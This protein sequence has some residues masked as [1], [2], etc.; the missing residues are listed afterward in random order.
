MVFHLPTV[1]ILQTSRYYVDVVL[2]NVLM[3]IPYC[4]DTVAKQEIDPT[5]CFVFFFFKDGLPVLADA[6]KG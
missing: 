6:A 3:A 2:E 5:L 1:E 4:P